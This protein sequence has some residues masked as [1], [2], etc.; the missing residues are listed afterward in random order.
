MQ[1]VLVFLFWYIFTSVIFPMLSF[2]CF[3]S[4]VN[5]CSFYQHNNSELLSPKV[6]P[7]SHHTQFPR[8]HRITVIYSRQLELNQFDFSFIWTD[9]KVDVAEIETSPKPRR[10]LLQQKLPLSITTVIIIFRTSIDL[11]ALLFI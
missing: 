8:F 6:I 7:L 2:V 11:R 5:F 1:M 4:E 9:S 3:H 10:C